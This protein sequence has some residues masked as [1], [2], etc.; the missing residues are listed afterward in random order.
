MRRILSLAGIVVAMV[1]LGGAA[2]GED[3]AGSVVVTI[4]GFREFEGRARVVLFNREKGFPDDESRAYRTIVSDIRNGEVQVRFD[5]LPAGEYA[6]STYHDE[7]GDARFNRGLLG[8]P[9]EGYGVSNNIV[10]A[11]RVPRFGEAVFLLSNEV[12][13][14]TVQVYY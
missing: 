14:M 8:I 1:A 11:T 10:H 4:K 7:N 13:E 9:T 3:G 6:L 5:E 2:V 12:K